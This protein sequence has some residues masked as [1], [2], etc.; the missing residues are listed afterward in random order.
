MTMSEIIGFEARDFQN[1]P[2]CQGNNVSSRMI[3]TDPIGGNVEMYEIGDNHSNWTQI[4]CEMKLEKNKDYCFKFAVT[5]NSGMSW[6]YKTQFMVMP[7]HGGD[8][9]QDDW[10]NRFVY[11]LVP[12]KFAPSLMK[13]FGNDIF[14]IY[15]VPFNSGATD[16]VRFIFLAFQRQMRIY[17]VKET[18]AYLGLP[19][20]DADQMKYMCT[21]NQGLSGDYGGPFYGLF[22]K[23]F[24]SVLGGLISVFFKKLGDFLNGN[25]DK[26]KAIPDQSKVLP[27]DIPPGRD[28]RNLQRSNTAIYGGE[29]AQILRAMEAGT[30]LSFSNCDVRDVTAN[31]NWGYPL[32]SS[33]FD[34]S[35]SHIGGRCFAMIIDK[36][37]F[38]NIIEISNSVIGDLDYNIAM[39]NTEIMDGCTVCI[40]NTRMSAQAASYLMS[41]IGCGCKIILTNCTVYDG[42][43]IPYGNCFTGTSITV[44]NVKMPA[45]FRNAL[46][47]RIGVGCTVKGL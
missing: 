18:E 20:L 42:P 21:S 2:T 36:S 35:N 37:G 26:T 12:G 19:D 23:G 27:N 32:D 15:D 43:A 29:L 28:I 22:G 17:P 40:S 5:T 6:D 10:N 14:R 33:R 44:S 30:A 38:N 47:R 31:L 34:I 8:K 46:R 9:G 13:K 25:S 3:V 7:L 41:K 24:F 11:D 4:S 1:D 39:S 45:E 16:K